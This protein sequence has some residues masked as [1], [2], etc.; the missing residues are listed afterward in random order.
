MRPV[1]PTVAWSEPPKWFVTPTTTPVGSSDG[2]FSMPRII[3][4]PA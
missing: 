2:T 1:E 4:T 3:G